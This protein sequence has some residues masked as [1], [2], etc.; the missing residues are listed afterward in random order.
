MQGQIVA[1]KIAAKDGKD[2]TRAAL[3]L[4]HD[5]KADT[6]SLGIFPVRFADN[7]YL[8][9]EVQSCSDGYIRR[10]GVKRG[11]GVGEWQPYLQVMTA[12]EPK[13]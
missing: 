13:A 9:G 11:A 12:K 7:E 3:V 1:F 6:A 5:E 4:E 2:I 10:H 8:P